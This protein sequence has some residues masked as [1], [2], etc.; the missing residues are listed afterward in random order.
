MSAPRLGAA[1]LVLG[2]LLSACGGRSA[3]RVPDVLPPNAV[4]P[5]RVTAQEVI[6]GFTAAGLDTTGARDTTAA[7][8]P[9]S[10]CSQAISTDDVVVRVFPTSGRAEIYSNSVGIFHIVA[11]SLTFSEGVSVDLQRR[12]ETATKNVAG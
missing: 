3:A 9:G 2:I 11:T 1:V 6:D 5:G 7:D 8:C 12:Y 4:G 10:G